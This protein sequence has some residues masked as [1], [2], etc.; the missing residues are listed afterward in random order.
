M[1]RVLRS[2][3][4]RMPKALFAALAFFAVSAALAQIVCAVHEPE[5]VHPEACWALLD[6]AVIAASPDAVPVLK[7]PPA[8]PPASV[9]CT[10]ARGADLRHAPVL[11]DHPPLS[12]PYHARTTR[13]LT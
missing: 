9:S 12:R 2:L 6:E 5:A 4:R 3:S 8:L 10:V 1:S 11:H 7:S 13:S